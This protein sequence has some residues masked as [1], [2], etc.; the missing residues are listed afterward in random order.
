[1]PKLIAH[2]A[3]ENA[4]YYDE[5]HKIHYSAEGHMFFELSDSKGHDSWGFQPEGV[6]GDI[7]IIATFSIYNYTQSMANNFAIYS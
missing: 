4:P 7:E 6:I 5:Q 3:S 1:M 2:V